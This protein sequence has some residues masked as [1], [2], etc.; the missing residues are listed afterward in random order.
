MLR[1]RENR[2]E[3][4]LRPEVEA[5]AAAVAGLRAA[6][7]E[8]IADA[9]PSAHVRGRVVAVVHEAGHGRAPEISDNVLMSGRWGDVLVGLVE[10]LS[11]D[12]EAVLAG[13]QA[14]EGYA[15]P[16]SLQ[17]NQALRL[18]DSSARALT[19][20]LAQVV[21]RQELLLSIPRVEAEGQRRR[22]SERAQETVRRLGL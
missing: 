15:P 13:A 9:K 3:L 12:L 22:D 16:S 4:A 1:D 5:L 17:L 21:E 18:V 14:P 6:V 19:S 7:V 11:S 8:I 20:R 2:G 10:P